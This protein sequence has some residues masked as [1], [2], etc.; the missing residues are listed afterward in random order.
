MKLKGSFL[1]IIALAVSS[2]SEPV[3]LAI[4]HLLKDEIPQFRTRPYPRHPV[5]RDPV[6]RAKLAEAISAASQAYENIPVMVLVAVAYR[7]SGFSQDAI[8]SAGAKSAFQLMPHTAKEIKSFEVLCDLRSI[9]GAA[10]CSAAWLDIWQTR[11][12]SMTGSHIV[13]LTGK[14]CRTQNKKIL[15]RARDR[16]RLAAYL[17][18]RYSPESSLLISSSD[19]KGNRYRS[20]FFERRALTQLFQD[21]ELGSTSQAPPTAP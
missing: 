4:E 3:Q 18:N 19:M 16:V 14:S 6:Q 13:Y 2:P 17:Q 11:C 10:Y 8:S 5:A 12:G 21:S 9:E 7:E 1:I 15:W 20:P